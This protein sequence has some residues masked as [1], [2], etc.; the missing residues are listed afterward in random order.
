MVHRGVFPAVCAALLLSPA[1]GLDLGAA[2]VPPR[3]AGAARVHPRLMAFA[4]AAPRGGAPQL[5]PRPGAFCAARRRPGATA[6][7]SMSGKGQSG[8][9]GGGRMER[10]IDS[11]LDRLEAKSKSKWDR[12]CAKT[13]RLKTRA[14]RLMRSSDSAVQAVW[15]RVARRRA[16]RVASPRVSVLLHASCAAAA[17]RPASVEPMPAPPSAAPCSLPCALSAFCLLPAAGGRRAR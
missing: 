1:G 6:G 13:E 17:G 5:A 12:V 10:Y 11:V 3:A 7:P 4:F 16:V 8:D 2:G 14:A 15:L 9:G